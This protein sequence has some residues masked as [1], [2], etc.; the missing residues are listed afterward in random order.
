MPSPVHP[1]SNIQPTPTRRP[2]GIPTSSREFLG[3]GVGV[4]GGVALWS[5]GGVT[6]LSLSGAAGV[7]PPAGGW[8]TR[9]YGFYGRLRR[10]AAHHPDQA[11]QAQNQYQSDKLVHRITFR[12]PSN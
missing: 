6:A 11:D 3:S 10:L 12:K 8:V 7:A 5:L 2:H 1:V 4:A 9:G